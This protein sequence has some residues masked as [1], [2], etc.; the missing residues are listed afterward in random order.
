MRYMTLTEML[1]MLRV[2]ARLS[3][4]VAHGTHLNDAHTLRLRRIQ[5]ELYLS[6]DW[7][8]LNVTQDVAVN[9]NQRYAAYPSM[10]EFS[11]IQRVFARPTGDDKWTA[12]SY[13]IGPDQLNEVDS[14]AA[15]IETKAN[16][17]RWQN[18]LSPAAEN[19]NQN[20]FEIWP[21][22]SRITAIRFDGRRK[23]FPLVNPGDKST[24]DG[25]LIVLHAAAE[26]LAA[27]KAEDASLRLQAAKDRAR[28]LR[29]REVSTEN[30]VH[31]FSRGSKTHRTRPRTDFISGA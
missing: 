3:Q 13:G 24:I 18:Y 5:E 21:V 12:L 19:L 4:N 26:I 15:P 22:P 16:V 7:P 2:E 1:D 30:Q 17:L 23:L 29:M 28:F 8:H 9:P 11:G 27:I 10:F 14:N 20:M 6:F 31:S 25:P